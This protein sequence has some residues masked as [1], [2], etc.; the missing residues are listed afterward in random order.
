MNVFLNFPKKVLREASQPDTRTWITARFVHTNLIVTCIQLILIILW[1]NHHQQQNRYVIFNVG[2]IWMCLMNMFLSYL[3]KLPARARFFFVF[4]FS[5]KASQVS[6]MIGRW[7]GRWWVVG[8]LKIVG[9]LNKST[10]RWINHIVMWYF[11]QSIEGHWTQ[12]SYL[13]K[14]KIRSPNFFNFEWNEKNCV[15]ILSLL[16][17]FE[18]KFVEIHPIKSYSLHS[19]SLLVE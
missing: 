2:R 18:E 3:T 4:V 15:N 8:R 13:T 19:C 6:L 17:G 1:S 16:S 11:I 12:N 9:V 5:Q 14:N 7:F 10:E